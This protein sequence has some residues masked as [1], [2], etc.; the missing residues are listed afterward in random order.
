[1]STA[2][3][4]LPTRSKIPTRIIMLLIYCPHCCEYRD[5]EEFSYSGEAHISRPTKPESLSDEEWGDYLF[6]RKNPKGIHH[7]MWC[8]SVG[9]RQFFNVTRNTLSYEILE[10][11]KVGSQP[12]VSGGDQ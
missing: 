11:Y 9:C 2:L 6:F 8:H 7:E 1:M 4:V 10:T 5:E 12:K 3:P